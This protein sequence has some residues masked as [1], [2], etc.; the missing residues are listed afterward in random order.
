MLLFQSSG[1]SSFSSSDLNPGEP[2]SESKLAA[3]HLC[4]PR[5]SQHSPGSPH[6]V[7]NGTG[8]PTVPSEECRAHTACG[9]APGAL[10]PCATAPA[11]ATWASLRARVSITA[12]L[13]PPPSAN[14]ILTFPKQILSEMK[15]RSLLLNT[16]TNPR[17][18]SLHSR[19][20]DCHFRSEGVC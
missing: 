9:A 17:L 6:Q 3:A 7:R 19:A 4:T 16:C 5:H 2:L 14:F 18:K 15:G 12:I 13:L 8:H 1:N 10:F 11:R 20:S